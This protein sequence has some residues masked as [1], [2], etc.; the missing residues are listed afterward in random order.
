MHT[1]KLL[2]FLVTR[3]IIFSLAFSLQ[4]R[5]TCTSAMLAVQNNSS[6]QNT[7]SYKR[8]C[9]RSLQIVPKVTFMSLDESV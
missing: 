5:D 8:T 4:W 6:V 3:L 9:L 1:V 2:G 7:I